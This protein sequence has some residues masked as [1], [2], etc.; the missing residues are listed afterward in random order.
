M[1]SDDEAVGPGR[2]GDGSAVAAGP[3]ADALV[4]AVGF[5]AAGMVS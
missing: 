5:G 3:S 4:W 1:H 2:V